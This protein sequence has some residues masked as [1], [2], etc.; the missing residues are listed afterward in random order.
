MLLRRDLV[1]VRDIRPPSRESL[2]RLASGGAAVQVRAIAL[3]AAFIA[4]TRKVRSEQHRGRTGGA[5]E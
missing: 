5:R 4:I 3:N 1:R 2:A